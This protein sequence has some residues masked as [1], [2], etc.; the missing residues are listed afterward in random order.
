MQ[1]S[2]DLSN[3]RLIRLSVGKTRMKPVDLRAV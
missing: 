2:K 1:I 3:S